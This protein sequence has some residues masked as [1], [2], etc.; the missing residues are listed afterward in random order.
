M[1]RR[2]SALCDIRVR[3]P[4]P[5]LRGRKGARCLPRG[6]R[7]FGLVLGRDGAGQ[8]SALRPLRRPQGGK[9]A[10]PDGTV[11]T[12]PGG[13]VCGPRNRPGRGFGLG[14]GTAHGKCVRKGAGAG[15]RYD[16]DGSPA[17]GRMI[18]ES[19]GQARGLP[20]APA[21]VSSR[22]WWRLLGLCEPPGG[23][24]GGRSAG[25]GEWRPRR[26]AT[27]PRRGYRR[28]RRRVGR[29]TAGGRD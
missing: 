21:T 2:F 8:T 18:H 19:D 14:V 15:R 10:R 5:T 22:W 4:R 28:S 27:P 17:A 13:A 7:R 24:G 20:T 6:T 29:D 11:P 25:G 26:P 3:L 12:K 16:S 23:R 9:V 1:K